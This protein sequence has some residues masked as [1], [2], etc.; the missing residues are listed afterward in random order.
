L[1]IDRALLAFT[2]GKETNASVTAFFGFEIHIPLREPYGIVLLPG[3]GFV[4]TYNNG[5]GLQS[6]LS[7]DST[8]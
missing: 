8:T 7:F 6:G 2:A 3:I 5:R 4:S 1:G